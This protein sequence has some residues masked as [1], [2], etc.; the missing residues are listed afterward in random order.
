MAECM[1]TAAFP[2]IKSN[3]SHD[4]HGSVEREKESQ[5]ERGH[6][7]LMQ[8]APWPSSFCTSVCH[9][10]PCGSRSSVLPLLH[11]NIQRQEKTEIKWQVSSLQAFSQLTSHFTPNQA[12]G[13]LSLCV[14]KSYQP[15]LNGHGL[16]VT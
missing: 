4:P 10:W 16:S 9:T 7:Q 13:T 14:S 5:A 6:L 15:N 3:Y 12:C 2:L 8:S 1:Y 11:D